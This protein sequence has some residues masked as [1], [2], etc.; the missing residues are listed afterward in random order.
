MD[1]DCT[2]G[3]GDAVIGGKQ[4]DQAEHEATNGLREPEAVEAWQGD[5][6][7]WKFWRG[8]RLLAAGWL[9]GDTG[10]RHT[11]LEQKRN[12]KAP[13]HQCKPSPKIVTSNR[14]DEVISD[15]PIRFTHRR[16][17]PQQQD[18]LESRS[19]A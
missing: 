9:S 16:L 2:P 12:S 3:D 1:G 17:R 14:S 4:S 15:L 19:M 10:G 5:G 18:A 8:Q 6:C 7:G 13:L 11:G